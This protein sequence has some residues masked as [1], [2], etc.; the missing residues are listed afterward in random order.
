[1]ER[2]LS[3]PKVRMS[4]GRKRVVADRQQILTAAREIGVS[5]GWQAVTIR[6]V[7][8]RLAYA[9]PVIY[10][11]FR[12]KEDLLTQIAAE[13]L[14]ELNRELR[15]EVDTGPET[16][17]LVL[18]DR[19]WNYMLEN[20]QI[21][22]LMNGMD[23]VPVDGS[24]LGAA[25]KGVCGVTGEAIEQWLVAQKAKAPSVDELTDAVWALLHGMASLFL[26]R[27]ASFDTTQARRAVLQLLLGALAELTDSSRA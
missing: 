21:Y 20:S 16:A 24:A 13:G 6:A 11:H 22:R 19:Y 1:M 14:V 26:A 12:N 25:A 17:I 8:D 18:A 4:R 23:G 15:Q 9:A 2:Q 27:A 7:A 10:E 5:D 3:S